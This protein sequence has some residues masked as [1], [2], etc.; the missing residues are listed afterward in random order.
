MALGIHTNT[1]SSW[2]TVSRRAFEDDEGCKCCNDVK[3]SKRECETIPHGTLM[4]AFSLKLI[5]LPR[6]YAFICQLHRFG[7]SLADCLFVFRRSAGSLI[8]GQK[9]AARSCLAV[10]TDESVKPYGWTYTPRILLRSP[11]PPPSFFYT[12]TAGEEMWRHLHAKWTANVSA[13]RNIWSG[14]VSINCSNSHSFIGSGFPGPRKVRHSWQL[15]R[16]VDVNC[17]LSRLGRCST[18]FSSSLASGKTFG[19]VGVPTS[20]KRY[21]KLET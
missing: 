21:R 8:S 4:G 3:P 11:S 10:R 12:P 14:C 1:L 15:V 2:F 16:D 9:L 6:S 18:W 7:S 20:E 19:R 17:T 5:F 13:P